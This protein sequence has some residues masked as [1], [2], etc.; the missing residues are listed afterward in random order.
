[1]KNLI[2]KSYTYSSDCFNK[3]PLRLRSN[4]VAVIVNK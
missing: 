2:R 4:K 3:D 1:M